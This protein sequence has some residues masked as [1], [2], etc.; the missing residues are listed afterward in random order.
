MIITLDN[1]QEL[2]SLQIGDILYYQ[3]VSMIADESGAWHQQTQGDAVLIGPV[4]NINNSNDIVVDPAEVSS[5]PAE[6]YLFFVKPANKANVRGYYMD[7]TMTNS[8]G[9]R[10]ELFGVTTNIAESSK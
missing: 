1:I 2:S 9:T 10:A 5:L 4:T 3:E 6:C 7:V 8:K